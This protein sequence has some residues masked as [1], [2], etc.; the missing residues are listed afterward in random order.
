MGS[1]KIKGWKARRLA[2]KELESMGYRVAVVERTGR[3]IKEKDAFNLF[4]LCGTN[5]KCFLWVQVTCN[6]PHPHKNYL[7]FSKE[8]PLKE[9]LFEQW[10][11]MD[12]KG[13]RKY[14]YFNGLRF[15]CDE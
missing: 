6:K 15:D 8:N 2:T 1:A 3:F 14:S 10:V 4:D 11:W 7:Q 9:V 13:F 5:G 12:R